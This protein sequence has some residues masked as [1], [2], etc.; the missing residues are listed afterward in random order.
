MVDR[1]DFPTMAQVVKA[2]ILTSRSWLSESHRLDKS[3]RLSPREYLGTPMQL[4]GVAHFAARRFE[5]AAEN[6]RLAVRQ[7]P[8]FPWAHRF[9]AASCAHLGRLDEAG[10]AIEQLS[11]LGVS[12]MPPYRHAGM[13]RS[14]EVRELLFF[15]PAPGDG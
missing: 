1:P 11:A 9:L 3:L 2:D 4:L 5:A 12:V 7:N 6:F 8:S 10:Q 14:D 13:L 15:G